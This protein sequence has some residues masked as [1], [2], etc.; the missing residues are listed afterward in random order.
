M[1]SNIIQTIFNATSLHVEY[2]LFLFVILSTSIIT[3]SLLY[4]VTISYYISL[5]HLLTTHIYV[6]ILS[7]CYINVSYLIITYTNL[8]HYII[9][10]INLN[11]IYNTLYILHLNLF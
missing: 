8:Y 7:L 2:Y 4:H 5:Y 6:H 1:Y 10:L 11:T 3:Y 9:Q